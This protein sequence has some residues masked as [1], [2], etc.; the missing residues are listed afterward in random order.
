MTKFLKAGLFLSLLT[1][2]FV[3]DA[4]ARAGGGGGHGGGGIAYIVLLPYLIVHSIIVTHLVIKKHKQC[5]DLMDK[6]KKINGIWD[7]DAIQGRIEEAYFKVQDAWTNRDQTIAQ[8]Y[9]S[10]RLFAK[11]KIQT[12]QM[13]A[14]HK[15][16]VLDRINLTEAKIIEVADYKDESK[17]KIWVYIKQSMIDYMIDDE[18]KNVVS[19]D[20]SKP[21]VSAELWKFVRENK[22]WV[23]DEIDQNATI[24]EMNS[25]INSSEEIQ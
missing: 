1:F 15:R 17:D 2:L 5:Q 8:S 18:T 23:L 9:M 20:S 19:G 21:E 14:D 12:D 4:F 7:G 6:L 24:K 13:I 3:S 25:L 16:N 22:E 11:H 10:K